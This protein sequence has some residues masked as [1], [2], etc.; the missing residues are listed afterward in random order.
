MFCRE[1]A[2][3]VNTGDDDDDDDVNH[4]LCFVHPNILTDILRKEIRH[5][6]L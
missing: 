6:W 3:T 2:P 4:T 5:N 1:T